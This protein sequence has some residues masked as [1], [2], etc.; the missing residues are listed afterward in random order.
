MA[1]IVIAFMWKKKKKLARA[2]LS[3]RLV[4]PSMPIHVAETYAL[5]LS[6]PCSGTMFSWECSWVGKQWICFCKINMMKD[7]W[8]P[9]TTSSLFDL[10][11]FAFHLFSIFS[12]TAYQP[13]ICRGP[14]RHRP[15]QWL[16]SMNIFSIN[17]H[18]S[19]AQETETGWR[20]GSVWKV[21]SRVLQVWLSQIWRTRGPCL[22]TRSTIVQCHIHPVNCQCGMWWLFL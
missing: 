9:F 4:K 17:R 3:R 7:A 14:Q 16:G 21:D 22:L 15:V 19:V 11:M 13:L 5:F 8:G 20:E 10:L 12:E 18:W 6:L 2:G 1:T